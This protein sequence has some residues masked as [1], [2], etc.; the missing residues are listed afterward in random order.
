[1]D[2]FLLYRDSN[3]Q[4]QRIAPDM[5]LDLADQPLT[6][7]SWDLD[8]RPPPKLVGE[9]TS[10]SSRKADF[11]A[12]RKLYQTLGIENYILV[13]GLNE[14]G[15]ESGKIEVHYWQKGKKVSPNKEG[16]IDVPELQIKVKAKAKELQFIDGNTLQ[17]LLRQD[18]NRQALEEKDHALEEKD[19][20]IAQLRKK[21]GDEI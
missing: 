17:P 14:K 3:G 19:R 2:L 6:N 1:M 9:L 10:P 12:N 4:K 13:D 16:Y 11:D 15:K 21:L 8:N 5:M 20:L 7:D 18:E